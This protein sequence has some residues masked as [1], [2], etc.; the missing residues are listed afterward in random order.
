MRLWSV[1]AT[2]WRRLEIIVRSGDLTLGNKEADAAQTISEAEE[3]GAVEERLRYTRDATERIYER[4]LKV[5]DFRNSVLIALITVAVALACVLVDKMCDY[6]WIPTAGCVI[7]SIVAGIGLFRGRPKELDIDDF[8]SDMQQDSQQTLIET[9]SDLRDNAV[10][11]AAIG[12]DKSHWTWVVVLLIILVS[13]YTI[14][15]K[16]GYLPAIHAAQEVCITAQVG[17]GLAGS[18]RKVR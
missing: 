2:I 10:T 4:R 8:I 11:A 3:D 5:V 14:S 7:V 12:R 15:I 17:G 18:A 16:T 9:I 1:I 6:G 13:G